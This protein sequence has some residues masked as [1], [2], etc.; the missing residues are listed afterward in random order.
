MQANDVQREFG[1]RVQAMRR[2]RGLTQEALADAIG[3]SVDTVSNIERG[4]SL[5]R[6]ETAHSIAQA[7]GTTLSDLFD[8]ETLAGADRERRKHLHDLL[9]LVSSTDSETLQAIIAQAEILIR[10]K[11]RSAETKAENESS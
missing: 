4:F 7:L 1:F 11:N 10:V 2:Q 5:T 6:I 9:E 8:F 3:R